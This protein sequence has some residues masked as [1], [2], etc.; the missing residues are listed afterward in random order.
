MQK[1]SNQ[2]VAKRYEYGGYDPEK[3]IQEGAYF[4]EIH[5]FILSST[6]DHRIRLI[7]KGVMKLADAANMMAITKGIGSRCNAAPV[8]MAMGVRRAA[9]AV[10]DII[11]VSIEVKRYSPEIMAIGPHCPN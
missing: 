4:D 11:S 1:C 3:Q 2:A 9:A 5:E 8:A 7:A 6:I 10:L